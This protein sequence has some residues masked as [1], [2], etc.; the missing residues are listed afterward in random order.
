MQV[1]E[2]KMDLEYMLIDGATG[3]IYGPYETFLQAR[4]RAEDFEQWEII[5]REGNLVDWSP[6]SSTVPTTT[7]LAA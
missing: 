4:D 1:S 2:H 3:L 5:N 6:T 7:E